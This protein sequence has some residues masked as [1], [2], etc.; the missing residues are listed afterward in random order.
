MLKECEDQEKTPS[1]NLVTRN[2]WTQ[3]K[4][5]VFYT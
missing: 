4:D 1:I 3:I 2:T 5:N